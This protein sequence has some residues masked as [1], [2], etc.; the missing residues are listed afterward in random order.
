[1]SMGII[2]AIG[3]TPLIELKRVFEGCH[4]RLYAKLESSNPG[5]SMKDRA[6]AAMIEHSIQSGAIRPDTV[7]VE[8]SSGNMGIGLAQICRYH[9]LRFICVVDPK[10]TSQ[11]IK[12]L[13]VYGAEIDLVTEPHPETGEFLQARLDRVRSLLQSIKH[14]FWPNQYCN[15]DNSLA[16]HQTMAEISS[17]LEGKI[18]YMFC[19]TS[20]CGTLRGCAE[21][22]RNHSLHTRLIA[23][24]AV[25]S[26]IFGGRKG[27]RIIPGH[28][29][30][31][32]PGLYQ[33][34]LAH[35]CVHVTDV[36]CI[37]GC[38]HLM[39]REA[40]LAGGSSGAVIMAVHAYRNII[41][42]N[43]NCVVLLADRGERYLDTVYSDE[44]V[45]SHFGDGYAL[46]KE[47]S[48]SRNESAEWSPISSKQKPD[49]VWR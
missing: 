45:T 34:G 16:H 8:S 21:Y 42:E 33:E 19:A 14:S 18:D 29:A 3:N 41:P 31:I 20:T 26:V 32:R 36:D 10:A 39:S 25:G 35:D 15:L 47:H 44:W 28:G 17:V 13:Q 48:Q 40:I 23:V 22:V 37:V 27:H 2:A 1:M 49:I 12:L 5:G 46:T 9:G 43:S 30:A 4:F 11:N 7:I 38:R 24:D 6:A